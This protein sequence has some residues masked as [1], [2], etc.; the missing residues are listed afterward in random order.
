M[1]DKVIIRHPERLKDKKL[2]QAEEGNT[3]GLIQHNK[4][5]QKTLMSLCLFDCFRETEFHP[6]VLVDLDL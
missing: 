5:P 6:E 4:V 3:Q 1:V 2:T